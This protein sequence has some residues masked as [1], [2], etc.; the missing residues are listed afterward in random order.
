MT[1]ARIRACACALTATRCTW[2]R[3]ARSNAARRTRSAVP[4]R[5][6]FSPQPRWFA[7]RSLVRRRRPRPPRVE[8]SGAATFVARPARVAVTATWA[9]DRASSPRTGPE[10]AARERMHAA[11]PAR[12]RA[13]R[14]RAGRQPDP[15]RGVR[16]PRV[17]RLQHP[18]PASMA[19]WDASPYRA[20][21]IYIGGVNAACSQPNLTST[22]VAGEVAAGWHMVP[23]YVGLQAPSNG[24]RC[25]AIS[26]SQAAAQGSGGRGRCRRR[27]A[28]DRDPRRQP[29]LQRHGGVL[30]ELDQHRRGARVPV[31]VDGAAARGGLLSGVYSSS[32]S[33]ISDL[34]AQY[35]HDVHRARRH[36]VCRM[37]QR[38]RRSRART[39]PPP[40]GPTTSASTSTAA[41]TTRPTA[42]SRSTST[43]TS[44]TA[45]QPTRPG[46][47]PTCCRRLPRRR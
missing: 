4:R 38:S 9:R 14:A 1:S 16:R 10:G 29:D 33:G 39:S 21:G 37:E 30:P 41:A 27:R 22:W 43:T 7:V 6:W 13:S 34:A 3:R 32:G 42:A 20:I 31:G 19:A 45:P 24:C 25:A 47:S 40:T 5:S 8:G 36:L 11:A 18:L 23:I 12:R 2:V 35:R 44:S 17:R 28:G 15:G 46:R 26:P